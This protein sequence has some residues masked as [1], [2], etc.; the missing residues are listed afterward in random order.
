MADKVK[1]IKYCNAIDCI[2]IDDADK[3]KIKKK[4]GTWT[5]GKCKNKD[6]KLPKISKVSERVICCDLFALEIIS[7]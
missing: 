7:D 4:T 1:D 5:M 3:Q 6:D 2:H